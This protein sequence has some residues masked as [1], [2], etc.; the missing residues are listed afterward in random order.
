MIEIVPAILTNSPEELVRLV[1]LLE[2]AGVTRA[3]LDV[4]DGEFVPT[5]TIAG[6]EEIFRLDTKLKFDVHLMVRHPEKYVDHWWRSPRADRFI[7]HVES[8]DMFSTLAE[9]SHGHAQTVFAAINPDTPLEKLEAVQDDCDGVQFMTVHPGLQGQPFL[10][11]VL[12]KIG[13]YR[14]AHPDTPIM[15]DGGITAE[16]AP[17][18][19]AAGASILVSGSY[20]LMNGGVE[21]ALEKLRASIS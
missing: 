14:K 7:Y 9:H 16:T 4:C 20:L 10:S 13:R 19:T 8:T 21:K 2:R 17:Q 3:H 15:V 6:Y 5:N 1:H 12:P 18:C 11:D